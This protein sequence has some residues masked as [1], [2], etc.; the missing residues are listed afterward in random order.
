M[1]DAFTVDTNASVYSEIFQIGQNHSG[2]KT[3][4]LS[5]LSY[6]SSFQFMLLSLYGKKNLKFL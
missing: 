6:N 4:Y 2:L 3:P 1:T 5:E